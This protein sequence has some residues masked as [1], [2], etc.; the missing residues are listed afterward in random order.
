VT[1]FINRQTGGRL[2]VGGWR[3]AKN[4]C[5]APFSYPLLA[6]GMGRHY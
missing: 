4:G 3:A 2:C 1:R 6:V 5:P